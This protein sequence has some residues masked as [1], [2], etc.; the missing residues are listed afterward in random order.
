MLTGRFNPRPRRGGDTVKSGQF[1]RAYRFQSTP[2]QGGR[3]RNPG[4][5]ALVTTSFNPRPRRGGDKRLIG[6]LRILWLF[7]S[8]PPQ[9]GRRGRRRGRGTITRFQSTPPQGGRRQ[10]GLVSTSA[11]GF[12][13]TPPQGGRPPLIESKFWPTKVSIHAPAGGATL[14]ALAGRVLRQRFNPR[15]RRGGDIRR[16]NMPL[17]TTVSIH[18]PA[19]GATA[20]ATDNT[21]CLRGFNPRPRRGG[22]SLTITSYKST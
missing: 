1:L 3:P 4:C 22:D 12:Q 21:D 9:G 7:Q 20:G 18:A 10:S 11:T 2:P 6:C 8:T 13:S 15:P 17:F 14:Q 16:P 5:A 19:G